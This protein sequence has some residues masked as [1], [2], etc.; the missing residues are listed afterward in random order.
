MSKKSEHRKNNSSSAAHKKS[1]QKSYTLNRKYVSR[2]TIRIEI[3]QQP[4]ASVDAESPVNVEIDAEVTEPIDVKSTTQFHIESEEPLRSILENPPENNIIERTEQIKITD[5]FSEP[6]E[7]RLEDAKAPADDVPDTPPEIHPYQKI[8][9]DVATKN[10]TNPADTDGETVPTPTP[11]ELKN[12]AIKKALRS[13]DEQREEAAAV[14]KVIASEKKQARAEKQAK[15]Q[16]KSKRTLSD[17]FKKEKRHSSFSKFVLAFATSAACI[18]I[19]GYFVSL[20]MPSIS[21][22][23]AAMQTGIEASYPTY[24]PRNYQL[25]GVSTSDNSTVTINFSG[26]DSDAFYITEEKSSWDSNALLNNYVKPEW[27]EDYTTLREQGITLYIHNSD[28]AW[29]N[30]GILYKLKTTGGSLSKKLI[31]NIALSL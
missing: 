22:R 28:A 12:E 18:G 15:K 23:V 8:I 5:A 17:S 6:E 25:S 24:V 21:V 27:G 30:G 2:P 4:A 3:E 20:N 1:T 10:I 11:R 13:L 31:K 9:D 29:V 16:S 19:L 26:K 14:S 7:D